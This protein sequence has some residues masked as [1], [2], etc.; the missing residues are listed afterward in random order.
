MKWGTFLLRQPPATPYF[1]YIHNLIF[2]AC[3]H[4]CQHSR[5]LKCVTS[6]VQAEKVVGRAVA[7]GTRQAR[8]VGQ[9]TGDISSE[10][11]AATPAKA[12]HVSCKPTQVSSTLCLVAALSAYYDHM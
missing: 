4:E 10:P 8:E 3:K 11:T 7:Q 5:G 12:E 1:A 2:A 6:H 9:P